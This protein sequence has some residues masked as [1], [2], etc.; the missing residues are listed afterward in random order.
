MKETYSHNKES[1]VKPA[2]NALV[3][4]MWRGHKAVVIDTPKMKSV[5]TLLK[6]GVDPRKV[7]AINFNDLRKSVLKTGDRRGVRTITGVSTAALRKLANTKASVIYA[8]YCGTPKGN[9]SVGF[10]PKTDARIIRRMLRKNKGL[11]VFTFSRRC[12]SSIEC[13]LT[14]V[15]KSGMNLIGYKTYC[16]SSPMVVV[17][18]TPANNVYVRRYAA[19][20]NYVAMLHGV[21]DPLD[22][23]YERM[24]AFQFGKGD[25]ILL[26]TAHKP[27]H[28]TVVSVHD[29]DTLI[30]RYQNCRTPYYVPIESVMEHHVV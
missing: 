15:R 28:A 18:A 12:S 5:D 19:M 29:D 16:D 23:C 8:D 20:W 22:E 4:M 1:K 21:A 14:A 25:K 9:K 26:N 10:C 24:E 11:A 2:V 7:I 30:V 6:F 27:A 3:S 17:F 13:A